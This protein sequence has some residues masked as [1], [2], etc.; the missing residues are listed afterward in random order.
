MMLQKVFTMKKIKLFAVMTAL[1]VAVLSLTG[2]SEKITSP[3]V[4]EWAYI[5]DD[6]TVVL[7]LSANGKASYKGEK[8]SY[9]EDGQYITLS[10]GKNKLRLRYELNN[11]DLYVYEPTTYVYV[12]NDTPNGLIGAWQCAKWSFEFYDDGTFREDGYFPGYY[13]VSEDGTSFKLMYTDHFEDTTCY[14]AINGDELLVEYP[15]RMVR[16]K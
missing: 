15:W 13:T 8:Y 10:S 1:V 9:T 16:M 5:H 11:D 4:G 6:Q 7:S 2:C 14:F 12:G 3:I